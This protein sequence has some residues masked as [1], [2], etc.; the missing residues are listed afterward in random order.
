M[1]QHGFDPP[2]SARAAA[3]ADLEKRLRSKRKAR[4]R[5][6]EEVIGTLSARLGDASLE[7]EV[8]KTIEL[9][10]GRGAG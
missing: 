9:G 4:S 5:Y 6:I 8:S 10:E 7:V 3:A 2:D 1:P